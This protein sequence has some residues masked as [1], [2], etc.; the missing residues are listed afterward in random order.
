MK[1]HPKSQK[2]KHAGKQNGGEKESI[3]LDRIKARYAEQLHPSQ[4]STF[5]DFPLSRKTQLGKIKK[6]FMYVFIQFLI[7]ILS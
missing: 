7:Y 5:D 1:R 4:I 3:E 6:M 2:G